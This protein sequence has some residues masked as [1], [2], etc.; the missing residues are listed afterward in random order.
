MA[1]VAI[2]RHHTFR[3]RSEE[4]GGK[5][6]RGVVRRRRTVVGFFREREDIG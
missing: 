1:H 3:N 2:S 6:V 5:M 4:V